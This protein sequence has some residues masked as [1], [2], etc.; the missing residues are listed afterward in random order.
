V[1][2]SLVVANVNGTHPRFGLFDTTR[3]YS[4][5][6]LDESGERAALAYRHAEYCRNLFV[7]AEAEWE[8]RP[9]SEWLAA[10]AGEIANLHAA[11]DWSFSPGG[12]HA[13]GLSL[14]AA[15]IPLWTH[16]SMIEECRI[17]SERA[18][19]ADITAGPEQARQRMK[20]GAAIASAMFLTQG[21]GAHET[22]AA[23]REVFEIAGTVGDTE[24]QLRALW[25]LWAFNVNCGRYRNAPELAERFRSL[26]SQRSDLNDRLIGA[27]MAG[28]SQFFL[29]DLA[30]A[31]DELEHFLDEY[32]PPGRRSDIIRY[33]F[34]MRVPA[35]VFLAWILWLRGLPDRARKTVEAGVEQA[36]AAKHPASLCYALALGACPLELLTGDLAGAERCVNSLLDQSARHVPPVW[37]AMGRSH[38]GVLAMLHG[39]A[40]TGLVVRRNSLD[41]LGDGGFAL[42]IALFLGLWAATIAGAGKVEDEIV[43]ID[44]AIRHAQEAGEGWLIAELVRLKGERLLEDAPAAA[45]DHFRLALNFA[46]RQGALSWELRAATSLAR[47][48]VD[49]GRSSD[50]MTVLRPVYGRFTEGFDTA[51]LITARQ[52]LGKLGDAG[53]G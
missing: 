6:K 11:L 48:L 31:G 9:T 12:D 10:Y 34:E 46:R 2:K 15:A 28:A 43:Q 21:A 30:T 39:D 41:E 1:A 49:R 3:A 38:R 42:R 44:D 53:G 8:T 14:T 36:W 7:R 52:L 5:E 22:G 23:W 17:R 18:L 19:A 35:H 16:L 4:L 47:L 27:R 20:L 37:H 24:Y 13:L 45:E 40:D 33:Q 26:A 51:D 25:G 50:A 29:G 32:V